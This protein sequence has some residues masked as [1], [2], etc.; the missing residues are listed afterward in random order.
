MSTVKVNDLKLVLQQN[1][2]PGFVLEKESPLRIPDRSVFVIGNDWEVLVW[3]W[4]LNTVKIDQ[5]VKSLF[6]YLASKAFEQTGT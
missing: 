1:R 5:S 3:A 6:A 2:I 4:K